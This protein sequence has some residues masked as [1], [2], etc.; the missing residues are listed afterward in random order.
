MLIQCTVN[1]WEGWPNKEKEC[2]LNTRRMSELEDISLLQ[3]AETRLLYSYRE[4]HRRGNL[5]SIDIDQSVAQIQTAAELEPYDK[6]VALPVYPD[7]D[8][9]ATPVVKYFKVRDIARVYRDPKSDWRCYAWIHHNEVRLRRY[10]INMAMEE[11]YDYA[12]TG[13]TTTT[14]T[15]STEG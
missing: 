8:I 3:V 5:H 15:T 7:D 11:V 10:L 6:F 13:T 4:G 9:T 14:T 1:R 2:I 12:M